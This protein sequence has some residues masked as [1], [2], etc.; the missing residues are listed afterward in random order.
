MRKI[1]SLNDYQLNR[2]ID[3]LKS[4]S[5]YDNLKGLMITPEFTKRME[6]EE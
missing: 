5:V 6:T 3:L 1:Q 2:A 4:I